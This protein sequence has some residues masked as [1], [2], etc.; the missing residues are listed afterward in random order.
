MTNSK[1]DIE[2]LK[3]LQHEAT[4]RRTE[5]NRPPSTAKGAEDQQSEMMEDRDVTTK[6]T[7][8]DSAAAK[9]PATESKKTIQDLAGQ[10]ENLVKEMEEAASERPLL[11]LLAAFSLGVITGQLFSR[12]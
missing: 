1:S 9:S 6:T 5:R 8:Q 11:A 2:E 4:E 10:I 3:G 7:A 12:R